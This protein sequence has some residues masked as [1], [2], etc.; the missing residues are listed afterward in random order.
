VKKRRLTSVGALAALSLGFGS[1]HLRA[2]VLYSQ[3][4]NDLG[5]DF[6]QNDTSSGGLGNFSTLYDNF[7]L[8]TTATIGSVYWVGSYFDPQPE[9][10]MTGVTISI[11][12]DNSDVPDYTGTPLYTTGDVSGNAGETSLGTDS[13]G[14]PLFSYLAPIDFTAIGGTQYWISIVPD[15]AYPPGWKWEYGTGGDGISFLDFEGSLL[16]IP[17]DETFELDGSVPEPAGALLVGSGLAL[18]AL[19]SRRRKSPSA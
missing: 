6:S 1:T 17:V 12:A 7:T 15:V 5:G 8:G 3:P 13:V 11:W 14:N 18:L 2:S 10:I 4:T 9:D 19:A 16:E